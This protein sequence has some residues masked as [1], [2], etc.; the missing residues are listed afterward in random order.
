MISGA[1]FVALLGSEVNW[2]HSD[3]RK[4]RTKS[5]APKK[6][7]RYNRAV[8][9]ESIAKAKYIGTK[10]QVENQ[11]DLI[12]LPEQLECVTILYLLELDIARAE[13]IH[14]LH[15]KQACL[16]IEIDLVLACADSDDPSLTQG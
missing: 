8:G 16:Y 2:E 15:Q 3:R 12:V 11:L 13:I 9:T 6:S 14:K 5:P 7:L 4:D 1:V 10:R